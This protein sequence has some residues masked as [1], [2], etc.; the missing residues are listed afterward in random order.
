MSIYGKQVPACDSRHHKRP[1]MLIWTF[2]FRGA[3]YWCP[4]CG[5]TWGMFGV[6]RVD[7]WRGMKAQHAKNV[8]A[9]EAYLKAR[10]LCGSFK[11]ADPHPKPVVEDNYE[12]AA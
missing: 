11:Y 4:M 7:P 12:V 6:P 2:A 8:A 10:A 5:R 9:T 3:E 1:P